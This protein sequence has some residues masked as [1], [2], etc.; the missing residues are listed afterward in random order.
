LRKYL[1][2]VRGLLKYD[3]TSTTPSGF[4]AHPNRGGGSHNQSVK[5]S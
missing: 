5:T 1:A 3:G 2:R 4:F